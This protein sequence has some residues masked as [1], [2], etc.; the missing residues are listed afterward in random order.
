MPAL[1]LGMALRR[2]LVWL[3]ECRPISAAVL[4]SLDADLADIV[5]STLNHGP[6]TYEA[7]PWIRDANYQFLLGHGV[8]AKGLNFILWSLLITC[9]YESIVRMNK[10][11]AQTV[12]ALLF[13][14]P[15][16]FLLPA[17]LYNVLLWLNF[18]QP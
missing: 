18:Y 15:A 2:F 13:V 10:P 1:R 6:D 8:V 5:S 14:V 9:V 12:A 4:F 17:V 7:N 11:F 16:A 3:N